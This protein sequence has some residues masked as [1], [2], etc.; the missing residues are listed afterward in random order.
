[1]LKLNPYKDID[2]STG[3]KVPSISHEHNHTQAAF[4]R[5]WNRG[6]RHIPV[7]NYQPSVARYP[8]TGWSSDYEDWID[9][10]ATGMATRIE[11]GDIVNF[12]DDLGDTIIV[13]DIVSSPICEKVNVIDYAIHFNPMGST[14]GDP[15]WNHLPDY[16]AIPD[17]IGGIV[18]WRQDNAL[19]TLAEM[20]TNIKANMYYGKAFLIL[21]HPTNAKEIYLNAY[22]EAP[23]LFKGIEGWNNYFSPSINENCRETY[24]WLLQQGA[25][26]WIVAAVD[27]QNY[28]TNPEDL[29]C[30]VLMVDSSYGS[31]SKAEKEEE[32]LDCYIEGRFYASGKMGFSISSLEATSN[33]VTITFDQQ[34]DSIRVI[35]NRGERTVTN[36]TSISEYAFS[37]TSYIRFEAWIGVDFIFTQPIFFQSERRRLPVLSIF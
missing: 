22:N 27:W 15:G 17:P 28:G 32:A 9:E 6:I 13:S 35:T 29:G 24:D 12:I 1:M 10:T 7:F 31:M 8:I 18:A 33:S 26:L 4:E 11:T 34:C 21:N 25:D 36:E 23:A 3:I 19:Y 14:W 2:F 30:N 16:P 20:I 37:G 5:S